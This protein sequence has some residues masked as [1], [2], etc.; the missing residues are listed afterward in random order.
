MGMACAVDDLLDNL[1]SKAFELSPPTKDEGLAL[2]GTTDA[3]LLSVVSAASKVRRRFFANRVKLNFL[4]NMKSG[5]CEEDC[6]YCSQA[7]GSDADILRYNWLDPT[8]AKEAAKRAVDAGAA[9]ICLVASGR[10]PSERDIDKV[11]AIVEQIRSTTP[12]VEICTSLGLL[13]P[14]QG[15]RLTDAGVF[16]YNHN[17]NTSAERY[18]E[19]CHTHTFQDRI[20]TVSSA[21]KAGL[22]PCSGAIFGMGESDEDIVALANDLRSLRPESVPVNFLLPFDGTPL[23]GVSELTPGR[24]LRILSLYR[25]FFP[26]V[27]V[28]AAAGREAHLRSLQPLALHV[29]NSIF[30]GDY[31]TSEGRPGNEDLQMIA[32]AGFVIEAPQDTEIVDSDQVVA[33]SPRWR[34]PGTEL[35]ANV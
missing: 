6:S 26:N 10:G 3:D 16:A 21:E 23:A 17:L 12:G 31:L 8:T 14:G 34:G 35:P 1:V 32:D 2:L 33:V 22:S 18:E 9:R 24:C 29:A 27:E 30:L 25:F 4:V 11:A 28:R 7:K 5:F 19:I 13:Q 20:S 15:E